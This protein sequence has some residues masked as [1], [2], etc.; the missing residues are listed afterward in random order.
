VSGHNISTTEVESALV[1]HP[2]VAEAAVVGV[3][4]PHHEERVVAVVAGERCTDEELSAHCG[5]L[6]APFKVPS[7]FVWVEELPKTSIGK[8]NKGEVKEMV[9]G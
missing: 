7:R 6:L 4:D 5:D 8:I 2:A 1:S 3:F 9:D